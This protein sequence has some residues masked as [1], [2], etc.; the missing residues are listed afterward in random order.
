MIENTPHYAT[1]TRPSFRLPAVPLAHVGRQG[2]TATGVFVRGAGG[3]PQLIW[4]LQSR[5]PLTVSPTCHSDAVGASKSAGTAVESI[6]DH[7]N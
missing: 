1:Q 5:A 2:M 4:E 3:E 7:H 6:H